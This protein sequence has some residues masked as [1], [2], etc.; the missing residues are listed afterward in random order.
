M[1][2]DPKKI[3]SRFNRVVSERRNWEHHWDEVARLVLP[4][5][6]FNN[7]REPGTRRGNQ[8]FDSTAP[9]ALVRLASMLHSL[10]TNPA[11]KWF[12][13]R[14]EDVGLM[15]NRAVQ[16]WLEDATDRMLGLF[17]SP[18]SGFAT[19]VH[20]VYLDLGAFGTGIMAIRD[21][22]ELTF[23]ARPLNNLYI[24]T[25]DRDRVV[26]SYRH[27]DMRAREMLEQPGWNPSDKVRKIAADEKKADERIKL[28]HAILERGEFDP[29]KIDS[30]N[31]PW[32]S[33]YVE[34]D[35]KH[36]VAEGGFH[37]NPYLVARWS[38]APGEDYGRSPAMDALPDIKVIN[39]MSR[40]VLEAGEI[41]VSPPLMVPSNGFEGPFRTAPRSINYY[42]S[43]TGELPQPLVTGVRTDIGT[44]LIAQRAETIDRAFFVDAMNLPENDRM[45]ATEVLERV[46]QKLQT[47]S[48][49]LSRLYAEL[50][51][52]II[53]RTF[54]VMAARGEFL[55]VPESLG[56][57]TVKIDYVSPLALSQKASESQNFLAF[58][59]AA[60]PL[61]QADPGA[62]QNLDTDASVR[63]LHS[64]HNITPQVMRPEEDVAQLRQQEQEQ[65]NAAAQAEI[66]ATVAGA[67]AQ[68]ASAIKDVSEVGAV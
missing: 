18:A 55:P 31:M 62:M 22:M 64:I 1:P 53:E 27:F 52:P 43:G 59:G 9:I 19:A 2:A 28:V 25:D 26:Q 66:A 57:Q 8:I 20:E 47:M 42:R 32:A 14:A 38:K 45:T 68:G 5:R 41:A 33:V 65:A 39:A 63:W 12:S 6:G 24:A 21:D 7:A 51:S 17:N 3:I 58:L 60:T 56:A 48:P 11:I 37:E 30:Q 67:A 34:E 49:V 50:L 35:S 44:D 13:L 10:L 4:T 36:K 40:T 54:R 29:Q 61:I 15:K 16:V 46:R 23:Q